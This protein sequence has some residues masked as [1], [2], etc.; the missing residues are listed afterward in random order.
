MMN[1]EERT[2]DLSKWNFQQKKFQA[3]ESTRKWNQE[4][5]KRLFGNQSYSS[6]SKNRNLG[7]ILHKSKNEMYE[8]IYTT[9]LMK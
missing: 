5:S 7:R 2:I 4:D 6:A 8:E 3:G 1:T 9:Q